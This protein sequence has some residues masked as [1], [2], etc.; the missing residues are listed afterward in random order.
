[1]GIPIKMPKDIATNINQND[2]ECGEIQ[3]PGN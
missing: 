2:P 3:V 1:M